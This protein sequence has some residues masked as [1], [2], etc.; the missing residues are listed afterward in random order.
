MGIPW[1]R[2]VCRLNTSPHGQVL[3]SIITSVALKCATSPSC[4]CKSAWENS[5]VKRKWMLLVRHKQPLFELRQVQPLKP[6]D[7]S[8][9]RHQKAYSP[10]PRTGICSASKARPNPAGREIQNPSV[11]L[12]HH[13]PSSPSCMSRPMQHHASTSIKTRGILSPRRQKGGASP[14]LRRSRAPPI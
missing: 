14:L 5:I 10:A 12:K 1:A 11:A 7:W 8:T 13:L 2:G 9:N 6:G 4:G 3:M